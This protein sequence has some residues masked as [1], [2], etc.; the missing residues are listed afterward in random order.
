MS[1]NAEWWINECGGVFCS[2]CGLYFDDYYEPA[3]ETCP[4]CNSQMTEDTEMY[5]HK[6]LRLSRLRS[7]NYIDENEYP[8][9]LL[10]VKNERRYLESIFDKNP[11]A[12]D[13]IYVVPAEE[14]KRI[15]DKKE[16]A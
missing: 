6:E 5:V 11:H 15:L 7:C 1:A 2:N 12:F 13:R 8:D 16:D 9:W 14:I 4:K 10:K 3:P